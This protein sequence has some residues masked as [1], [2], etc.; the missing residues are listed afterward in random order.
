MS[1]RRIYLLMENDEVTNHK[2]S[3]RHLT[4][5]VLDELNMLRDSFPTSQVYV[6]MIPALLAIRPEPSLPTSRSWYNLAVVS[7]SPLPSCDHPPER[8]RWTKS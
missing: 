5:I 8:I 4:E 3:R 7:W 2:V 1:T 6:P